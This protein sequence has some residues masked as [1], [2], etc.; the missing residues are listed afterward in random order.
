MSFADAG[1]LDTTRRVETPEG[2]E[3]DLRAAGPVKRA[4]AWLVDSA[5]RYFLLIG[6]QISLAMFGGLGVGGLLIVA[7]LLVWG[8]PVFF[9]TWWDGATPGK[10]ALRLKVVHDDGTAVS[11]SSSLIRNVLRPAD[12]FPVFYGLG[13][14]VSI[15]HPEFKRIGDVAARTLVIHTTTGSARRD[16]PLEGASRRVAAP[17]PLSPAEQRAVTEFA[18]RTPAL[19]PSRSREIAAILA[20]PLGVPEPV[21]VDKLLGIAAWLRGRE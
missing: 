6:A 16:P 19:G 2:V 17:L 20:E 3:L 1:T 5:I 8:Y 13:L 12:F 14:F 4:A 21:A 7:F 11:F 15:F 18:D 9:E 10:R